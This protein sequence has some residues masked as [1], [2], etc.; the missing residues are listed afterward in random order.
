MKP[1]VWMSG[2]AVLCW[3]AV[4]LVAPGSHPEVMAGMLAPLAAALGTWIAVARAQRSNP[5]RVTG[6]LMAGFGAKLVFFGAYM[7]LAL[8]RFGVRPVPFV[9]ALAGFTIGL[10][11]MEALFLQRLFADGLRSASSAD[12]RRELHGST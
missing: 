8:G 2:S 1:L 4:T 7:A 12:D 6:V 11:V 3:G 10:Y 5:A 9:A